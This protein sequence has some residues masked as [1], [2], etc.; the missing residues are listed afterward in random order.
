MVSKAAELIEE[1][2]QWNKVTLYAITHSD[3][4][5]ELDIWDHVLRVREILG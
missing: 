3:Q 2:V 1:F 4:I 5:Q